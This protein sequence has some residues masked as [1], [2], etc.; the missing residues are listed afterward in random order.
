ME[1]TREVEVLVKQDCELMLLKLSDGYT[2]VY[3]T[4]SVHC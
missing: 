1:R 2:E 3:Y 4:I